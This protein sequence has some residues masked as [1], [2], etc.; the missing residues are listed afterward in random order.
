MIIS[1]KAKNCSK[2]LLAPIAGSIALF[3]EGRKRPRPKPLEEERNEKE[4][5]K[6][7]VSNDRFAIYRR[8][9]ECI[10]RPGQVGIRKHESV[11]KS[12]CRCMGD[13][14]HTNQLRHRRAS[15]TVISR[16]EHVQRG[17][18]TRR[19]WA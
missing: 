5:C 11:R 12:N 8:R 19:V 1:L 18:D 2:K 7:L 14:G 4:F 6:N 16:R 13:D 3:I 15:R 9:T 17:R 10:A